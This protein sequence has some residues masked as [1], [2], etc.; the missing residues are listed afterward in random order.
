MEDRPPDKLGKYQLHQ[1]VGR[2]GMSDVYRATDTDTGL[3]VG[4][5][6]FRISDEHDH[7]VAK[8]RC[9]QELSISQEVDHPNII[10]VFESGEVDDR[11]YFTMEFVQGESL[12][13]R[14]RT[15][16]PLTLGEKLEILMQCALGLGAAHRRNIVH[17]DIKPGN[18]LLTY[19]S[20]GQVMVKIADFGIAADVTETDL[21]GRREVPGTPKYLA[22]EIIRGTGID[23]RAD[24]FALGVTAYEMFAGIDPFEADDATAYLKANVEKHPRALSSVGEELP[25]ELD[26]LGAKMLAKNPDDRYSAASLARDVARV[27]RSVASGDYP[28]EYEDRESAFYVG[29]WQPEPD[30]AASLR[31]LLWAAFAAT[32][33]AG[34]I[35]AAIVV[36][37]GKG[38]GGVENGV[39]E[40]PA[41]APSALKPDV[42]PTPDMTPKLSAL[43]S[44][45]LQ[46]A[47]SLAMAG[48]L[49]KAK[50]IYQR[51]IDE[52][53][54]TAVQ[55]ALAQRM[56]KVDNL[57]AQRLCDEA[58]A[59]LAKDDRRGCRA[60]LDVLAKTY[61]RWKPQAD[62]IR[63]RLDRV[64]ASEKERRAQKLRDAPFKLEELSALA[65]YEMAFKKDYKLVV[66]KYL[67]FVKE[68]ADTPEAAKAQRETYRLVQDWQKTLAD[69]QDLS[70]AEVEKY[71]KGCASYR[72]MRLGALMEQGMPKVLHAL[73][74]AHAKRGDAARERRVLSDLLRS[75]PN[76]PYAA[77]AKAKLAPTGLGPAPTR[78]S[79]YTLGPSLIEAFAS[80]LKNPK[81]WA[82]IGRDAGMS[83]AF[84]D[85]ELVISGQYDG[86]TPERKG[87]QMVPFGVRSLDAGLRFRLRRVQRSGVAA[88]MRVVLELM[89][90]SGEA[91]RVYFDGDKYGRGV[92]K[93]VGGKPSPID[94]AAAKAK[95]DEDRAWHTLRLTYDMDTTA[96]KGAVDST[97]IGAHTLRASDL[98]LRFYVL[99]VNRISFDVRF[100]SFFCKF[101]K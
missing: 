80:G 49:E 14:L 74:A 91:F 100:D 82:T 8:M 65:T 48:S 27:Q 20:K 64:E 31:K 17:R 78:Q 7:E 40:P 61:P 60:T 72:E 39:V 5:K 4:L 10:K 32:C 89:D 85:A 99:A 77:Q 43:S 53:K 51:L 16:E 81:A 101:T 13:R 69:N 23:G 38:R 1:K 35:T 54:D 84:T 29:G 59:A 97:F 2:G 73:A 15:G 30:A 36:F 68:F 24:I 58:E 18:I 56:R 92:T 88:V 75:Y 87:L 6:L 70:A 28:V 57:L 44:P 37:R 33:V 46:K 66:D 45:G 62:E 67:A 83:L 98:R 42:G 93:L 11:H 25:P 47:D 55:A 41:P 12:G 26:L 90:E 52:V 76:S 34:L 95:G 50:A 71:R 9:E 96:V 86:E 22:P 79:A 3:T 21:A 94:Q 63:A 19:D